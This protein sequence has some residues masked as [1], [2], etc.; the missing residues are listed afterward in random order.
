MVSFKDVHLVALR[1][2]I[3][4]ICLSLNYKFFI[5]PKDDAVIQF[6]NPPDAVV[7]CALDISVFILCDF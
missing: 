3:I 2:I 5:C 4:R 1:A 6:R 7:P